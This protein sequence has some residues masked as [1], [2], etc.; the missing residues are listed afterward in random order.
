M[1]FQKSITQN[2]TTNK[3]RKRNIIRFN[4]P[5]SANVVTKV[6]KHFLSLLDKHFPS[7]KKFHRIFNRSIVHI[8][9]SCLPNMKTILIHTITK[10]QILRP[11]LKT[12]PATAS[13]KQNA[14]L[15]KTASLSIKQPTSQRKT[16]LQH[17]WN[18]VQSAILK[19]SKII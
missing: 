16:L 14:R 7:Q 6:W 11:S 4:P 10:L 9:Y 3:N 1:R 19:P 5:Y 17:R 2:T 12:D 18:Y 13:I 8:S 15:P